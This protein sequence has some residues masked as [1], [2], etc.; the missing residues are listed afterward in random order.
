MPHTE[1]AVSIGLADSFVYL[2]RFVIHD[3]INSAIDTSIAINV[4]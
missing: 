1:S 3:A 2:L 4:A